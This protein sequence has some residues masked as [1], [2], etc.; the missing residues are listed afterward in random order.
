MDFLRR[1]FYPEQSVRTSVALLLFR[2]VAGTAF[3]LHGA[4]K[5]KSP[6]HWMDAMSPANSMPGFLQFLAA[7]AEFG[8][9]IA[10]L[11]GGLFP[12]F[13]FLILCTMIVAVQTLMSTGTP[14][15]AQGGPS[16]EPAAIYV[17]LSLLFLC[18]GPGLF[19]V[20]TFLL[21]Q[22]RR[23]HPSSA[24]LPEAENSK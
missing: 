5:M 7:L 3:I 21:S 18:T 17:C 1:G 19:A 6:F 13:T 8:G 15:V 14:F 10:W 11:L 2:L 9:G 12:L 16:L 20:D 22:F 4:G 23:N 24:T